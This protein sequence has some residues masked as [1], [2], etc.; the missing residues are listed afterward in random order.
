M[1]L[2]SY[3]SDQFSKNKKQARKEPRERSMSISDM[4]N[5]LGVRN[6]TTIGTY[7]EEE[8]PDKISIDRYIKCRIQMER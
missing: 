1:S 8:N 4:L 5:E 7:D 6:S 3:I 2:F